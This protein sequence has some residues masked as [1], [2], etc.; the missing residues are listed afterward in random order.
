MEIKEGETRIAWRYDV[1]IVSFLFV[2]SV[3][4]RLINYAEQEVMSD[5]I[6]YSSNAYAILAY[7]WSWPVEYMQGHPPYFHYLLAITTYLFGGSFDVLRIV[8]IFLASLTVCVIYF[9][10]KTLFDRRV[11][12]LSAILL[13]FSSFHILYSRTL[14]LEVP[15]IFLMFA[16][17]FFFWK[18]YHKKDD[19]VNACIA[20]ILLGLAIG[21]K[22][23]SLLLY[24]ILIIYLLWSSKSL[25][26]IIDKRVILTFLVSLLVF[27][28][29]LITLYRNDV[30]PFYWQLFKRFEIEYTSHYTIPLEELFIRG[31]N[32][33]VGILIDKDSVAALSFS[34][35]HIF[36]L[37]A[38]IL[39]AVTLLYCLQ[40]MFKKKSSVRFLM[41]FFIILN[42]FIALYGVRYQ[43]YLMSTL[44]V[45][46]IMMSYMTISFIDQFEVQYKR[47]ELRA[48]LVNLAKISILIFVCIFAFSS[49]VIGI[50]AP[51]V[52][53]PVTSCYEEYIVK[54]KNE[55]KFGEYIAADDVAVIYY[56]CNEHGLKVHEQKIEII[57]LLWSVKKP[58]REEVILN[59]E[60]WIMKPRYIICF[61]YPYNSM[62]DLI[63]NKKI[64]E[65]YDLIS[66]KGGILLFEKKG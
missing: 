16:A 49:I 52:N 24:P 55:I 39:L 59:P 36:H 28:P 34:G 17:L 66:N 7:G 8:P 38:L 60:I 10:G 62:V 11:G 53:K 27:S 26:S 32:N 41:I 44:P 1:L 25:K 14:M 65:N 30:N 6:G 56:Y 29:V 31:Y 51:F 58:Q 20:G 57:P 42:V 18:S 22:Y 54:L 50:M 35:L 9:L 21:T 40:L 3:F 19:I 15:V 33:Y 37:S 61:D 5:E 13:S 64:R 63:E 23:I 4:I 47:K 12:F 2:L 48:S 46:Y 43:Y 45:F